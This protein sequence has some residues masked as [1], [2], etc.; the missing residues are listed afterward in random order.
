[1]QTIAAGIAKAGSTD[2]EKLVQGLKGAKFDSPV[3]PLTMRAGDHQ[4]TLGS[5]V[6]Q[7]AFK[8]N[9]PAFVN[10]TFVDGKDALISEEEGRKRRPAGAN[11]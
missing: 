7:L 3:G 6:G 5:W 11:D 8:D 4:L 10:W 1:M 2:T 9:K